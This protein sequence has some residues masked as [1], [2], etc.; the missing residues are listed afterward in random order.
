MDCYKVRGTLMA[1]SILSLIIPCRIDLTGLTLW[2]VIGD[3]LERGS[4]DT[5]LDGHTGQLR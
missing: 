4:F 2:S 1:R 5:A 3:V